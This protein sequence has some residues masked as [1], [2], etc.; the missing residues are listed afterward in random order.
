[1]SVRRWHSDKSYR[2]SRRQVRYAIWLV[3][4][5]SKLK[6]YMIDG[7][8]HENGYHMHVLAQNNLKFKFHNK[9]TSAANH[10]VKV[11]YG[12]RSEHVVSVICSSFLSDTSVHASIT[13]RS[14]MT[15]ERP[16]MNP[17]WSLQKR[18]FLVIC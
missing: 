8:S 4:V 17:C 3:R 2:T 7:I 5:P 13:D 15:Q 18:L 12:V 14:C 9:E 16:S 6:L 11:R 10:T 1:M